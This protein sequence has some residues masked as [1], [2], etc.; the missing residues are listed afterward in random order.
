MERS[1]SQCTSG[2]VFGINEPMLDIPAVRADFPILKRTM[3][4][5]PLV[6]LDNGATSLKPDCV[7]DAE[8]A[9]Y[10]DL[11]ANI[12]RGVY[13]FSEQA[14]VAYDAVRAQ[15]EAFIHAPDDGH[16]IFT[17]STTESINLVA[18]GWALKHLKSG[19]EIVITEIEHHSNFVPWQAVAERTGAVVRF[20]PVAEDGT[21]ER[22]GVERTLTGKTR[23]VAIT[24]MSNV[25]GYIPPV[26]EI[27]AAAHAV[28]ALVLVDGA[29][30]VSHHPVDVAEWGCDF[31]AFS[32]HKM[33]GP[34]GVGV[35]YARENVLDSM[36]PFLFGGDMIL[37]VKKEGT[38]YAPLPAKF[39]AG[40]PNIAGVIGFGAAL[41]YLSN[42][43]LEEIAAHE[44]ELLA[45]AYERIGSIPG[46][47]VY[48]P[49]DLANR[50]GIFSF[51]IDDV[52]P[53]DVGT[54]LDR[55]GIA[56]R[57][58]FHCAQP[59]MRVFG[60][61]GT[62]RA[63]FY[64]YNTREEVDLLAAGVDAVREIFV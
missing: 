13:E 64:V 61:F 35:L 40:T 45:Y 20:A 4:G 6:Y 1:P 56:V 32:A 59:L 12:H 7:L 9:Y 53:H 15:T 17:K 23:L 49:A 51:N 18:Y 14:T 3:R 28:G 46:V 44:K 26:S 2:A 63:S 58:G 42:I 47:I 24:A 52:H 10:T 25:T 43:G 5:K 21:L 22:G 19:D 50:G 48:G 30:Y 11:G 8:R 41:S 38:T 27:V 29:Q 37:K 33:C 36:D 34:T 16:A 31:L 60:V 57:A 62:V 55:E 39:E 54:I